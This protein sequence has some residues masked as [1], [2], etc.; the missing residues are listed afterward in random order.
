MPLPFV[1][2]NVP[3]S[4]GR[5]VGLAVGLVLAAAVLAGPALVGRAPQ[6]ASKWLSYEQAFPSPPPPGA[7]AAGAAP[8]G[9]LPEVA[10]W[11]DDDRYLEWRTDPTDGAR[12]LFAVRAEDG[13]A[14][15]YR[16]D[17]ALARV[18][19]DELDP[20]SAVATTSDLRVLVFARGHDLY[21]FDTAA[22]ERGLRRLTATPAD[23]Q[24]PRFSPDGRW[25]AYTREGNL[26]GYDLAR[27]IEHQFTSDGGE[28]VYNGWASWVYMEEILGRA[29]RYAAFWWAPDSTK[30]AFLRF[31]DGPVP[32]FPIYHAEG[33][34]G[35]LERQRYPKAGDPNPRVRVGVVAVETGALAWMDFDEQ[36]DQYLAWPVWT[37]DSRTLVVQWMNRGQDTI[38]LYACDP[39]A[40][41][42]TLVFEE[43]QPA[44]VEW[45][46]D[47]Y[48]FQDGS[49]FLLRSD[50]DGWSHLYRY[51]L[52]GRLRRRLTSG[53]WDVSS[54]ARVDEAGGWVYFLARPAGR[55]WDT[56]LRRVRVDGTGVETV[57]GSPG[58]HSVR[59]S[60]RGRY[61]IDTVSTLARPPAMLLYRAD[62][63][64]VRRL[65]DTWTE[66]AAAYAW[67]QAELFTIPSGDG[68]DLPAYWIKPPDFDPKKVY[69]V[70]L[71]IYGGPAAG[72]VRNQWPGLPPHYWAE[73]GV[74]TVSV[75]HR[76]SGHFGKRGVALMHRR[77]G[78]WEVADLQAAARW[79]RAKPFVAKDRIGITGSSYGG[80][81][82][83]LALTKGA[84]SFDYGIAGS[85]VTDWRLY[86][87]V[88]TER[89]MDT[90]QEN[91]EGYRAAA[92][93][94]YAD[95]Y[96][97]GTLRLTHG[98]V[99]DNVH[100]Q[101]SLQLVDWLT[102]HNRVFELM[103]FPGS[104]HGIQARQR[105]FL[106][107]GNH[108]FWVRH[109]LGGR[110][111][112]APAARSRT[113]A[114]PG[115]ARR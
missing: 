22:P 26:Y 61:V 111:P 27:S 110:L 33:Q 40:G 64:L 51:G 86:D 67:G 114:V 39:A 88:Y 115:E 102:E 54:I 15:V 96:R 5:R 74:V 12:R 101:N 83:L 49:G 77:L 50:V 52:D 29:S 34:H 75:D 23:E 104:R 94:T 99:D 57:I 81:V 14:T 56:E 113:E 45:F 37:P 93:L 9:E 69:P 53:E 65:G 79:L 98:T 38:R 107:R 100:L 106:L 71:S 43:R 109:L 16:D 76:G 24:N 82:T 73:R 92:V 2:R 35:T 31:D 80:Y 95:R 91:P 1:T 7:R 66:A 60:P 63:T 48:F 89:Y 30:I 10:G 19:P 84:G 4:P 3:S 58:T 17:A 46:E 6:A 72:T 13:A 103:V 18:L 28:H 87:T 55:T 47:L 42:K 59:V 25:L 78:T 20:R 62:G 90:P 8:L 32:V 70:I 36:A 105:A 44:W 41:T 112:S 108:D 68:Y 85:P 21:L 11:L 97:D